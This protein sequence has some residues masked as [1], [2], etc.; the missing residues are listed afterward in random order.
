MVASLFIHP[1]LIV[2]YKKYHIK[3][4][5][6]PVQPNHRTEKKTVFVL[7]AVRLLFCLGLGWPCFEY[8]VIQSSLAEVWS[9]FW[10]S[11]SAPR[12]FKGLWG[13]WRLS[14]AEQ[15]DICPG[16]EGFHASGRPDD[17]VPPGLPAGRGSQQVNL[18][19][20]DPQHQH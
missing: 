14:R 5:R 18:T 3:C 10:E 8:E 17:L 19:Q 9:A 2:I 4:S 16:L 13:R 11:E 15:R 6:S 12:V 1:F 20:M 7:L